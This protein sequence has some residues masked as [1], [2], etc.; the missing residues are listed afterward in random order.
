VSAR[1]ARLQTLET[2]LRELGPHVVFPEQT[3]TA[4]GQA[5]LPG[6]APSARHARW[7]VARRVAVAVA[8]LSVAVASFAFLWA[9]FRSA[10]P[11]RPTPATPAGW[12]EA[13]R[14]GASLF[15]PPGGEVIDRPGAWVATLRAAGLAPADVR[16]WRETPNAFVLAVTLPDGGSML[17]WHPRPTAGFNGWTT[18]RVL[19]GIAPSATATDRAAS[20][21][22]GRDAISLTFAMPD[23]STH[24]GYR[25]IADGDT[26][27]LSFVAHGPHAGRQV[28]TFARVVETLAIGS[29]A[30]GR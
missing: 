28:A 24:V 2:A 29:S 25:V 15:L 26:W 8:A 13:S 12:I 17:V 11:P 16:A 1:S 14:A 19:A 20:T 23:A 30:D 18:A 22:D 27:N 6:S 4:A 9:A 7:A 3:T 21:L 5:H 10:P